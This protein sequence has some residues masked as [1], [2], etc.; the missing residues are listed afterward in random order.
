MEM[1]RDGVSRPMYI[2]VMVVGEHAERLAEVLEPHDLISIAGGK[3]S[4]KAGRTKDSGKLQVVTF[5][6]EVLDHAQALSEN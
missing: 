3:L 6:V 5:Y 2:P 1:G 4:W